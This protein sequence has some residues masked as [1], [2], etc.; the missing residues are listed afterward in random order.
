MREPV[1]QHDPAVLGPPFPRTRPSDVYDLEA[2][3]PALPGHGQ[4]A[5]A[6]VDRQN[7]PRR[8]RRILQTTE[9]QEEDRADRDP[10]RVDPGKEAA[11][12]AL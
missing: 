1:E 11:E 9:G 2:L 12:H 7:P 10:Y 5:P 4:S 6:R 3:Q 8:P